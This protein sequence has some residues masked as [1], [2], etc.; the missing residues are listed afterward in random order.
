LGAV[1]F[2]SLPYWLYRE[3]Q[4]RYLQAGI[5]DIIVFSTFFYGVSICLALS[6]MYVEV[7]SPSA[8][9]HSG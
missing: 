4:S 2:A 1:L 7:L 9:P 5:A 6:A 3:A 8:K